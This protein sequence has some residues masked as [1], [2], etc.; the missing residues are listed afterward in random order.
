MR[1]GFDSGLEGE[2][3]ARAER[4]S[5]G[6]GYSKGS[7]LQAIV[8]AAP[9]VSNLPFLDRH[10]LPL[11]VRLVLLCVFNSQLCNQFVVLFL[12]LSSSLSFS[13]APFLSF[14][15]FF[16]CNHFVPPLS[17]SFSLHRKFHPFVA[18]HPLAIRSRPASVTVD[19]TAIS[20][21]LL[22]TLTFPARCAL[23]F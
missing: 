18:S 16:S 12:A 5:A 11:P 17:L 14:S 23:Q 13:H 1:R 21:W 15:L 7:R 9:F 20:S 6:Q 19:P 3:H 8:P 10:P 22:S 4:S 2:R